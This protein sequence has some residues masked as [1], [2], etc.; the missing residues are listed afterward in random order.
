[1]SLGPPENHMEL[2]TQSTQEIQRFLMALR[3][4]PR[5]SGMSGSQHHSD[6][7]CTTP[8]SWRLSD[9]MPPPLG[10]LW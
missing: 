10:S 7:T 6:L 3:I 1:M 4:T 8:W 9:S 5:C 2:P